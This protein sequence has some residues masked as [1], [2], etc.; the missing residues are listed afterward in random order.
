LHPPF[1]FFG[2]IQY[3]GSQ[4]NNPV[5]KYNTIVFAI[6]KRHPF[7]VSFI[8]TLLPLPNLLV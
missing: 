3:F 5:F 2:D 6:V 1:G 7:P 8:D 4:F